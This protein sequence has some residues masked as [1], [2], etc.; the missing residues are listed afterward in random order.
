[1]R[2]EPLVSVV[3]PTYRRPAALDVCLGAL[4]RQSIGTGRFDVVVVDDGTP[5]PLGPVLERH[6]S[7]LRLTVHRQSRSG[8]A[9]ARNAGVARARGTLLAF[10]DDDC[11][12]T[13]GWLEALVVALRRWPESI[14]GGR[15]VNALTANPYAEASQTLLAYLYAGGNS[16]ADG[17]PFV[18]SSN[19]GVSRGEFE[20]VGGFALAFPS[21]AAEDRDLCDRW[22]AIGRP[23]R[24]E[25]AAVVRH[26]HVMGLRGFA[27]QHVEYGRGARRLH[28]ARVRRG[29]PPLRVASPAFY[30]RM[31]RY[32]FQ[33]LPARQA[34]PVAGLIALSQA[35][36]ATGFLLERGRRSG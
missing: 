33:H 4:A 27:R 26:A 2:A 16:R 6:S 8:P 23:L 20:A 9:A 17:L 29:Q 19:L 22:T 3:V 10:T 30:G 28:R 21:A 34:A 18:A 11:I 35:A 15:T 31:L 12:P 13:A 24:Y 1:M 32:P 36:A 14:V 5:E 25:P 7:S